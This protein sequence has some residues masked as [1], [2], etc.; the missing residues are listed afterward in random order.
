[1]RIPGP[2]LLLPLLLTGCALPPVV[3][4]ASLVADGVSFVTTGKSTT[5]HA[6]SALADEDCALLRVVDERPICDPDGE[7]LFSVEISDSAN[8]TWLADAET[9]LEDPNHENR[10]DAAADLQ[11]SVGPIP[12]PIPKPQLARA[13]IVQPAQNDIV[14]EASSS[15]P[16]LTPAPVGQGNRAIATAE[17]LDQLARAETITRFTRM[18]D[19]DGQITTYA[20]I[21]SFQNADN[22]RRMAESRNGEALVQGF[23]VNG[24]TTFRVLVDQPVE[25]ARSVGFSDAWPVRLCAN[26]LGE[27]P[28]G[29]FVVSGAGVYLETAQHQPRR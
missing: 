21:G 13:T 1:M 15:A 20:V 11:A 18:T 22:A 14:A 5:D 25:Q 29:H 9:A 2:A 16:T 8:E 27:P 17:P 10:P 24:K 3:T 12:A 6:I 7:V 26:D 23:V 28:C 19:Q 4:V